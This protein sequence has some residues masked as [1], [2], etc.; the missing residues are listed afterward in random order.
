MGM[1]TTA[2]RKKKF[3]PTLSK[4]DTSP[5]FVSA[6]LVLL[7]LTVLQLSHLSESS[8]SSL[9]FSKSSKIRDG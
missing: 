5:Y 6:L 4:T 3:S 7:P 9:L 2:L 1:F 8:I